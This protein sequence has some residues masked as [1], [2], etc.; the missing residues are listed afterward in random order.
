[1]LKHFSL[2]IMRPS[3]LLGLLFLAVVVIFAL[4]IM[5]ESCYSDYMVFGVSAPV[6]GGSRW[7]VLLGIFAAIMGWIVAAAI[8]VRNSIKQHTVNTLLNSRLSAEYMKWACKLN[9]DFLV[10]PK[11]P[12]PFAAD[13]FYG[14]A[15]KIEENYQN[16]EIATYILNYLEFLAVAIRHGDLDEA[17]VKHTMKSMVLRTYSVLSL[18]IKHVRKDDGRKAGNPTTLE[19][20][21]WLYKRWS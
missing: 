11:N 4:F 6:M 3:R 20:L 19:H 15:L 13:L 9:R 16:L 2:K 18:Y 10:M 17:M 7:L 12:V 21:T 5:W 8:T 14:D 1:M